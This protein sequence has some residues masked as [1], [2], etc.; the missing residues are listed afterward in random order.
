MNKLTPKQAAQL[1]NE[2]YN[3]RDERD[4]L[5]TKERYSQTTVPALS[6]F[7]INPTR[8]VGQSGWGQKSGFVYMAQRGVA[9]EHVVAIR[10]TASLAD[11][12]TD[13]RV[14][15]AHSPSGYV[16]HRGFSLGFE[17]IKSSIDSYFENINSSQSTVHVLGHSLGGALAC[18]SAEHLKNKK[19]NVKLYTFGCPRVGNTSYS[20]YLD[21]S[22][23]VKNIYRVYHEADPVSMI[24]LYPFVPVSC[25]DM[26]HQLAWRG[27]CISP[28]A[29]KMDNYITSV[30]ESNWQGL[31][32]ANNLDFFG[33][34]D[35][36]LEQV[37]NGGGNITMFS[38]SCLRQILKG[39]NWV[40]SS[41]GTIGAVTTQFIGSGA[42]I[43]ADV[44]AY[45]LYQGVLLGG[46]IAKY[47]QH[48]LVAIMKFLGRAVEDISNVTVYFI[49]YILDVFF[50][51]ISN[52]ARQ[53]FF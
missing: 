38:S 8:G 5:D 6:G 37:G 30:G 11:V 43:I 23:G 49:R 36:W 39:L 29:H 19:Y 7:Q 47:V 45:I 4:W 25:S 51:I 21:K 48:I 2:V 20:N 17:S 15:F 52:F 31:M 35:K 40:L 14:S 12:I 44:L 1:A 3:V 9:N 42:V 26:G 28:A 50:R 24:P 16:V 10:G 33:A 53:S 13:A 46:T 18:L 32:S 22:I 34:M 27:Y 41:I